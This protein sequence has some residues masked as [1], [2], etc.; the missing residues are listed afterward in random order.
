MF[1]FFRKNKTVNKS[2]KI[3]G[4][5]IIVPGS[6]LGDQTTQDRQLSG[7]Y[8]EITPELLKSARESVQTGDMTSLETIYRTMRTEWPRFSANLRK[9]RGKVAR[10]EWE[11]NAWA[12]KDSKPTPEAIEMTRL[13]ESALYMAKPASDKWEFG[14]KG[15]IKHLAESQERGQG[16]L[17]M[18]WA[19]GKI[20]APRAYSPISAHF[21]K[22]STFPNEIDRL[23][24]CPDGIGFCNEIEF[25]DNKFVISI[26]K[27]GVD[28]PIYNSNLLPLVAWFGAA[29]YGL[30]WLMTFCQLFGVPSR[31]ASV[32]GGKD[33]KKEVFDSLVSFGSTGILILPDGVKLD[34]QDN[35][36]SVNSLP[37]K[38]LIDAA[39]K[40][41]DILMLG[42]TLTT[43]TD[44]SGS[45]ALGDVHENTENEIILERGEA[46][47]DMINAQIIPA[48][49]KLNYGKLP[50]CL[51]YIS[52]KDPGS[53]K[54]K[55]KLEWV[56]G[57][58]NRVKLPVTKEWV[59]SEL[60]VPMPSE[61]ADVFNPPSTDNEN[62]DDI[63]AAA[64]ELK[65]KA[66]STYT[67]QKESP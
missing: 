48:I 15:M 49:I 32:D 63:Q 35:T 1:G 24:L 60:D 67:K 18:L 46:V 13:V 12:E 16:V 19:P 43:S 44:N 56:D 17:E 29:K 37:Q 39:D 41:C 20:I 14:F 59:Y 47:A 64:S 28:H 65:K 22:W 7:I 31:I 5:N 50:D 6:I 8:S 26:N 40:I 38:E 11:I 2:V 42:Q 3:N 45:R 54:S 58:V 27:D 4:T 10:L 23:K 53:K 62:S 36:K 33:L 52:C 9:I 51:P 25:P 30:K 57:V 66:L 21:Y 61:G 55:Q 34:I